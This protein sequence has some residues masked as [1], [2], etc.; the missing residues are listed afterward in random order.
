MSREKLGVLGLKRR[1]KTAS[2]ESPDIASNKSF[3]NNLRNEID[4]IKGE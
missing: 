4:V 3:P 1:W 2:P